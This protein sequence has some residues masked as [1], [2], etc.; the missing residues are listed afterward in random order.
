MYFGFALFVVFLSFLLT[1]GIRS[2]AISRNIMDVPNSRS[3][4]L[5]PTPR[6]GGGAFVCVFLLMLPVVTYVEALPLEQVVGIGGA[7]MIAAIVGLI[8]DHRPVAVHWRLLGHF[9]AA[10]WAVLCLGGLPPLYFLSVT[11]D[12]GWIG[13]LLA[14]VYLVWMLNLYNFMDGIDGIASAEA[15]CACLGMSV[16]CWVS[17]L[18]SLI[19][20]PLLLAATVAGFLIWNSPPSRIFM[21]DVGSGFLG[22]L[23]GVFSIQASWYS[24]LLLWGWL[25]LLGVFV[26]DATFTLIRRLLLGEKIHVAHRTHAYQYA[27]RYFGKH[28]PV[29]LAV[30]AINFF[31]LF[32]IALSMIIFQLD[33]VLCLILAYLP[34]VVLAA[35]FHAGTPEKG[36]I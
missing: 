28:L 17:G 29:T 36:K 15:L 27:S 21:G 20:L 13:W 35:K 1:W 33:G 32:P 11:I 34:L 25:I 31:W 30:V 10:V 24:P 2:Y 6:G 12:F 26:V 14:S 4:H 7:G 5:V 9:A 18:E 22:I 19:W 3:S 23:L 8:D 16:L